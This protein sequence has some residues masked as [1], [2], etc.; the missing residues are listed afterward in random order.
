MRYIYTI[1]NNSA[2]LKNDIW[3]VADWD[4]ISQNHPE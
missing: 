3:K 1:E 4:G 2:V